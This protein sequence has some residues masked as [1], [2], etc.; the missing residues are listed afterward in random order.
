MSGGRP[1]LKEAAGWVA[2]LHDARYMAATVLLVLDVPQRSVRGIMGLSKHGDG[3]SVSACGAPAGSARDCC[4]RFRAA[5]LLSLGYA[6]VP[7]WRCCGSRS[8][9]VATT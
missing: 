4:L 6:A 3:R 8:R 7:T 1:L 2:R 5:A 9:W